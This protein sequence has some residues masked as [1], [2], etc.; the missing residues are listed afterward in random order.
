MLNA[1]TFCTQSRYNIF[2]R[3]NI[4]TKRK[5]YRKLKTKARII[6]EILYLTT[7]IFKKH[8]LHLILSKKNSKKKIIYF[9]YYHFKYLTLFYAFLK[10][11]I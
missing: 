4:E 8:L 10:K 7:L 11:N 3:R 5:Y 2:L 1:I 6:N 9:Q